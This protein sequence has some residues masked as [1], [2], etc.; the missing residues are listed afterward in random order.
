MHQGAWPTEF[1]S[2][3]DKIFSVQQS[4]IKAPQGSLATETRV[5]LLLHPE[6]KGAPAVQR[7]IQFVVRL[8][9]NPLKKPRRGGKRLLSH[10][11]L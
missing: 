3:M 1:R 2:F 4:A 7:R 5:E 8:L 6:F 11:R 10:S 9:K